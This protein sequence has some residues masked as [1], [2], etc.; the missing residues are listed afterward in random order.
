MNALCLRRLVANVVIVTFIVVITIDALPS[1]CTAHQR[2]K[3]TLDPAL[4]MTG[5]WQE[6]WRL[7][8]PEPD[9]INTRLSAVILFDDGSQTQWNSPDWQAFSAW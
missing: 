1:T 5:L 3:N 9:T 7:F 2:L 6:P 4:D 8:A